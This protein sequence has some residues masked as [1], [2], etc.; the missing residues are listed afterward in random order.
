M[1]FIN[2]SGIIISFS[3]DL[4]VEYVSL[5][6][7]SKIIKHCI[8]NTETTGG[9]LIFSRGKG[10]ILLLSKLPGH[11]MSWSALLAITM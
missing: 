3:D 10:K 6:K 11:I 5:R 8:S 9:I 2:C 7:K 1:K 4:T